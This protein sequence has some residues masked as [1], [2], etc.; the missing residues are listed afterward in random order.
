M[1]KTHKPD[2]PLRPIIS[3]IPTPTYNLTKAINKIISPYVPSE[4]S[5][6]SSN[7]F[8]DLLNTNTN[9]GIIASL[10]VVIIYQRA[11]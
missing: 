8:I 7:D 1:F 3:Q 6:K 11:H 9:H 5:L 10:D 2:N 4:Y